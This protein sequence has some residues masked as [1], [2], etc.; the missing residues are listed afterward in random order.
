MSNMVQRVFTCFIRIYMT[1]NMVWELWCQERDTVPGYQL[2]RHS[3]RVLLVLSWLGR[4]CKERWWH[5]LLL[6]GRQRSLSDI[7]L[8]TRLLEASTQTCL[9][10]NQ[11]LNTQ[12]YT[13]VSQCF[14]TTI[15]GNMPDIRSLPPPIEWMRKKHWRQSQCSAALRTWSTICSL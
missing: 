3:L 2:A 11:Y 14:S 13:K 4:C 10:P 8:G 1:A 9:T 15:K 5:H 12:M 7:P 6:S